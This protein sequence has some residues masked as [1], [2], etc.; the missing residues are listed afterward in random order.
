MCI[1]IKDHRNMHHGSMHPGYMHHGHM[2]VLESRALT[3][4]HILVGRLHMTSN[5]IGKVPLGGPHSGKK[6]SFLQFEIVTKF[7]L[8]LPVCLQGFGTCCAWQ[9]TGQHS[10]NAGTP[11]YISQSVPSLTLR[12]NKPY[13]QDCCSCI[14]SPSRKGPSACR[15]SSKLESVLLKISPILGGLQNISVN[16]CI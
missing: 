2:H 13:T 8:D 3:K 14:R 7:D 5:A 1:R 10:W 16:K 11:E 9:S 4:N 6:E 15:K 12:K